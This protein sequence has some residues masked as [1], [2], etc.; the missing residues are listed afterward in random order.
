MTAAHSTPRPVEVP[1]R[2]GALDALR[3][4]VVVGLVFFHSALVF[5]TRDDFYVKNAQTVDL[6]LVAA[7]GVVWAMPLLFTVAGT[8]AWHSMQRRG[9]AGF[10]RERLRRLGIPLV[11][12]TVTLVPVPQWLR[13]RAADPGAAPSYPAFLGR[14]FDVHVDLG[15]FPFV[16]Q[17][18][19]FETGHLWFVVLLLAFS[20]LLL[21]VFAWLLT[22]RGRR[23]IDAAVPVLTRPGA[24]LLGALPTAAVSAVLGLEEGLGGWSRW[25]Y[26]LFFGYGFLLAADDRIRA[27]VRRHGRVAAVLGLLL[28]AGGAALFLAASQ[29]GGDPL[30]ASGTVA[31]AGRLLYGAAGWCWLVAILGLLDRA[32]GPGGSDPSRPAAPPGGSDAGRS[33]TRPRRWYGYLREA[34]LPLYVLHQPVVVVAAFW[35]T[36]ADGPILVEYLLLVTASLVLTFG[37]YDL[38]VRR[39]AV[40]RFLFGMRPQQAGQPAPSRR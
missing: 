6:T 24:V 26:L 12:A 3:A 36:R 22:G 31:V 4:L 8:A 28:F 7:V 34:V 33:G 2:G 9:A 17:G 39:T 32:P 18:A 37:V 5:D 15:A 35:I 10:A 1:E 27:A 14:F 30:T 25:A 23:V 21:P 16:V 20:F 13:E 11:F 38:L 40:T 19:S 29:E